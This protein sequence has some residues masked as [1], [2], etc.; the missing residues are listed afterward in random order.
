MAFTPDS[1]APFLPRLHCAERCYVGYSGGL[2]SHVLLHAL[3]R[4]LGSGGV[5]PIHINHQLSPHAEQWQQHCLARCRDLGVDLSLEKVSVNVAGRGLEDAAR[6]ARYQVFEQYLQ[7][8]S[9]LLLGHHADDQAETVLYRLLRGSGPRG[10]AGIPVSRALGAG[11]LLRPL[12]NFTRRELQAYAE[13]HELVWV[14]DES[15]DET[16]FDRNFIRH[17]LLP[18]LAERW[19]DYASRIAHSASRCRDNEQL[20]AMLAA[21]DLMGVCERPERLGWSV[22]L[23]A[24]Q[25]LDE[26]RQ[27][28]LLHYWP[29]HHHLPRPGHRAVDA[30]LNELLPAREDA[31]PLVSWSGAQ[32]RRF[33]RRLYLL[34]RSGETPMP[35]S[36]TIAW[37]PSGPLVLPDGSRLEVSVV[38]GRGVFFPAD[39]KVEIRYRRGG[40]RCKPLGRSGSNTLKKLFLEYGLEPW[41]RDR[42]PLIYVDGALAVVAD[43]WICEGFAAAPAQSGTVIEWSFP[44]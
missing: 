34:P 41:L 24:L 28:N 14:E 6:A 23:E 11:E 44:E 35:P 12:L 31:E 38:P 43:L 19:P 3:V 10:L 16:A 15:N 7:P 40:E 2:D 17:R 21:Q 29:G 30:I 42:V 22:D 39:A 37:D 26:L 1:L 33:R 5:T 4:L 13:Q 18:P 25:G 27:A 9:L 20:V 8:S 36:E 32:L